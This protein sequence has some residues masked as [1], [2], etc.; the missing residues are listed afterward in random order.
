MPELL[1]DEIAR[2]AEEIPAGERRPERAGHV[3]AEEERRPRGERREQDRGGVVRGD[4]SGGQGHRRQQQ[5]EPRDRGRPRPGCCRA[6]SRAPG[7][8]RVVAVQHRVRPPAERP[9]EE[10]RVAARCRSGRAGSAAAP[11][12]AKNS[13]ESARY[14]APAAIACQTREAVPA[15]TDPLILRS[16]HVSARP[17]GA[18][19]DRLPPRR[20][21]AHLPLQLALRP[22]AGRRVPPADREHGH[23]PRGRGGGRP[24]PGVAALARD[25][26]GRADHLPARPDGRGAHLRRPAARRGQGVRGR[27]RDPLPDARRGRGRLGRRR[28]RAD[29]VRRTRAS[30]T[31]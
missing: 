26:L 3:P 7:D 10:L 21:C 19:P 23:E 27:G 30:P 1:S 20:R 16:R 14:A 11:A 8:E 22:P 28:P 9:G 15:Y 29:R 6:A 17:H 31:S 25:R 13:S 12:S 2:E 18:E 24:D 5:R 4:G